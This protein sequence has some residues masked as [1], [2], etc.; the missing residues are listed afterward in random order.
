MEL[1]YQ[2]S[3]RQSHMIATLSSIQIGYQTEMY[4]RNE[5]PGFL[6]MEMVIADGKIQ[7]WYDI[8]GRQSLEEY[9][10]NEK[11]DYKLLK[12][13]VESIMKGVNNLD[14][15]LLEED[16][17][18]LQP[19]LIFIGNAGRCVWLCYCQESGEPLPIAFRNL[20]EYLLTKIN[21]SDERAVT[22][23]YEIYQRT[24]SAGYEIQ[25]IWDVF[26][27]ENVEPIILSNDNQ[28]E[29]RPQEQMRPLVQAKLK[30]TIKIKEA[31]L[32]Q[33]DQFHQK[34]TLIPAKFWRKK[35]E[36][37]FTP[38]AIEELELIHPTVFL[39]ELTDEKDNIGKLIGQGES[40][41]KKM[42][43]NKSPFII[44]SKMGVDGVIEGAG[45][46]RLHAKITREND[47]YY[48]EDMN[49]TNGTKVNEKF[50]NYMEHVQL[51]EGDRI[52]FGK[53]EYR[54]VCK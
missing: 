3:L 9:L 43:L 45:V 34:I 19:A 46:S 5:I 51:N 50:L 30:F 25:Q 14:S 7:F 49:S 13:L 31:F 24:L 36:R 2:R 22:A 18:L 12:E 6:K 26:T 33:L 37:V 52:L 32:Q 15:Y 39:G 21:H 48:I 41:E 38:E 47:S 23:G 17:M 8:T 40:S 1:E 35:E 11:L 42:M 28:Q 54:F 27:A 29:I 16:Q 53:A 4:Q 10:K 44:G 20:M